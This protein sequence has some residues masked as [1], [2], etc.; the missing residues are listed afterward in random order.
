MGRALLL[1]ASFEPLCVVPMRRAVVLVLKEKAE[2]VARNGAELHSERADVAGAVGDPARPL[3]AGAVPQPG[4]RSRAGPSSP[5][6]ATAASTATGRPRTS[7][8]SCPAPGAAPHTW[9]NVVA[10]CRAC[11]ARKEDRLP[12]ESG[13][14]LRRHPRAPHATLWLSPPPAPST[15]PG[16]PTSPTATESLLALPAEPFGTAPTRAPSRA[17]QLSTSPATAGCAAGKAVRRRSVGRAAGSPAPTRSARRRAMRAG[18]RPDQRCRPRTV[19]RAEPKGEPVWG[20]PGGG[21]QRVDAWGV[22]RRVA[23]SGGRGRE[24]PS[25]G[26][27]PTGEGAGCSWGSSSTPWTRRGG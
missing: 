3:R 19:G 27:Q 21:G 2:I 11:N 18:A 9:D 10:S 4:A 22:G 12:A 7:T 26:R 24:S 1:N 15:P 16:S 8:T 25:L 20:D 14:T 13:L 23:R 17:L 6:T 5:V